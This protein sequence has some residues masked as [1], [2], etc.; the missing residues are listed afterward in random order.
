MAYKYDF[1]QELP[2]ASN[3]IGEVLHRRFSLMS[4]DHATIKPQRYYTVMVKSND[5]I[6]GI[7]NMPVNWMKIEFPERRLERIVSGQETFDF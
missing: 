1:G 4:T 5:Y 7:G 6:E 2:L 3:L